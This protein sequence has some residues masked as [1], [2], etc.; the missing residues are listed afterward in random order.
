MGLSKGS[1]LATPQ[2]RGA[3]CWVAIGKRMS[4]VREAA[5]GRRQLGPGRLELAIAQLKWAI[6]NPPSNASQATRHQHSFA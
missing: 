3:G 6:L 4:P 5:P 1:E 2:A